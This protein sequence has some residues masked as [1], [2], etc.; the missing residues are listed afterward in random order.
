[1]TTILEKRQLETVGPGAYF[2]NALYILVVGDEPM[3]SEP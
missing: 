1:M 3:M 2:V